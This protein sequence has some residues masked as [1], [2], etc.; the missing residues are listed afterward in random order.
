[1]TVFKSLIENRLEKGYS[2]ISDHTW[3]TPQTT[4]VMV[5][6]SPVHSKQFVYRVHNS[7]NQ[8]KVYSI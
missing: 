6:I 5:Y 1:M 2:F 3:L 7:L 4:S 8:P